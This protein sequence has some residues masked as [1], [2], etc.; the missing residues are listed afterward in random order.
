MCVPLSDNKTPSYTL[1]IT[2][3]VFTILAVLGWNFFGG[4]WGQIIV[5]ISGITFAYLLCQNIKLTLT[6]TRHQ[7]LWLSLALSLFATS[8]IM[9]LL[10]EPIFTQ[11]REIQYELVQA[12]LLAPVVEEIFFRLFL[13]NLLQKWTGRNIHALFISSFIFMTMHISSYYATPIGL[14]IVFVYGLMF[15]GAF[16]ISKRLWPGIIAHSMLNLSAT[17]STFYGSV[18]TGWI[19]HITLVP[20]LLII[21]GGGIWL[22]SRWWDYENQ[23]VKN[24]VR[25][26]FVSP[27]SE[28]RAFWLL[29]WV[30]VLSLFATLLFVFHQVA[31]GFP[32]YLLEWTNLPWFAKPNVNSPTAPP[33]TTGVI[34]LAL[35]ITVIPLL[36]DMFHIWNQSHQL[37]EHH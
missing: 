28:I 17:L 21:V 31:D 1:S 6:G 27:I 35:L 13:L 16:I 36:M 19:G 3:L 30:G 26:W 4:G 10:L 32:F 18:I 5:L 22:V 24:E 20:G 25:N 11:R 15:G 14:L 12:V 33:L 34:L 23:S 8:V 7:V 37:N 2:F 29:L 9:V